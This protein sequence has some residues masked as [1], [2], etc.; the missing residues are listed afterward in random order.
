MRATFL[1]RP[2]T[3]SDGEGFQ[4]VPF[5]TTNVCQPGFLALFA[6]LFPQLPLTLLL[7]YLFSFDAVAWRFL[8]LQPDQDAHLCNI[9]R[10]V[11][12]MAGCPLDAASSTLQ[13]F[14]QALQQL[15]IP[16]EDLNT[17]SSAIA[18]LL[19]SASEPPPSKKPRVQD[20]IQASSPSAP[21]EKLAKQQAVRQLS[22]AIRAAVLKQHTN[23]QLS[24]FEEGQILKEALL[25]ST[26]LHGLPPTMLY[27][28][29]P[30]SHL[31]ENQTTSAAG[32]VG[33][34]ASAGAD[35]GA[36]GVG[37]GEMHRVPPEIKLSPPFL[38]HF[39]LMLAGLVGVAL[40]PVMQV[41]GQPELRGLLALAT[42]PHIFTFII[43]WLLSKDPLE[44][45]C[46]AD[47]QRDLRKRKW[48][49][50]AKLIEE[51]S[52]K[53]LLHNLLT[54]T[55]NLIF[56]EGNLFVSQKNLVDR[57]DDHTLVS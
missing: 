23:A 29:G 11:L 36:E 1:R 34:S 16:N 26:S 21:L 25:N 10:A 27:C 46:F 12:C 32:G 4:W 43:T 54:T 8:V 41:R 18:A 30:R 20:S 50:T 55:I 2:G 45:V 57:P 42:L 39:S 37:G 9:L 15:T 49:Y 13:L 6:A 48:Q 44:L 52:S 56:P 5:F 33:G 31:Q 53:H 47:F 38:R 24:L 40:C 7:P 28:D 19:E 35:G 51:P 14:H 22:L 17:C 3:D